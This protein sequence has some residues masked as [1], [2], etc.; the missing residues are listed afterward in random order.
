[1]YHVEERPSVPALRGICWQQLLVSSG[2]VD[3]R[4]EERGN[5]TVVFGNYL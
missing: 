5:C 3:A 1:M 2:S 4:F